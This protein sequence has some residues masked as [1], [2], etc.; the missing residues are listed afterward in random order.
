MCIIKVLTLKN[1]I[2]NIILFWLCNTGYVA[3]GKIKQNKSFSDHNS[4]GSVHTF[5]GEKAV[6]SVDMKQ[7]V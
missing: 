4:Q 3:S 1:G 2:H 7:R 5:R 6:Y